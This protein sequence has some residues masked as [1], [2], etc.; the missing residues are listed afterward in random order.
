MATDQWKEDFLNQI[1]GADIGQFCLKGEKFNIYGLPFFNRDRIVSQELQN[2][3][4]K[5]KE[6]TEITPNPDFI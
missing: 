6:L 5:L 1:Q 4:S 3:E 2:F